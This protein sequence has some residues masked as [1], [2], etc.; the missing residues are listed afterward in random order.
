MA[1]H[2]LHIGY[3]KTGST[4]LQAWFE[5]HPEFRYTHG[6]LGGFYNVYE[7]ARPSE[8]GYKF[9][10]TSFEGLSTP[11]VAAGEVRLDFGGAR[12]FRDER[13]KDNQRA[14]C[15]LLKSLFPESRVLI[16]TRGFRGMILSA[17]SQSVRMGA[18][19]HLAEMC[20]ELAERLRDDAR[21]YYDYDFL[22][23]L[24]AET[25]G[26][27]N[28][29]ILPYELLRDDQAKFLAVLEGRLG[30]A[31][32]D[33][34]LGRVN[35]SLSPEELYWYPVISRAVSAAAARLG[36]ARRER[37]YGWYVRRTL[38]NR[39][40]RL[41]SVLARLRP[42]RKITP[43]DFPEEILSLCVGKATRLRGDPLYAPYAADYLWDE[44]ARP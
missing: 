38:D 37:F 41:V 11:H 32:A 15:S 4:F 26:A 2:L 28:L 31:H 25:F 44:P 8:G 6:G 12:A 42:G 19:L 20:G 23:G 36:P 30:V 27:E 13:V 21:H 39:L 33:V 14:A 40:R 24:Y 1:Q 29:M 7:L 5:C 22:V 18:R 43:A 35:P 16:M 3:P 9:Y 34:D 10:V 17:Y